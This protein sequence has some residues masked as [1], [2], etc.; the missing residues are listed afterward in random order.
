MWLAF[1]L[2]H[3]SLLATLA[4][5]MLFYTLSNLY[6]STPKTQPATLQL[7]TQAPAPQPNNTTTNTKA[8]AAGAKPPP[9][10]AT[11]TTA[12]HLP[13]APQTQKNTKTH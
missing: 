2:L 5:F 6:G 11:H 1:L 3:P 8:A 7:N 13:P 4:Y 10:Q 12:N 9:P